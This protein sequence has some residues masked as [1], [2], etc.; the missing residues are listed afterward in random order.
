MSTTTLL[1]LAGFG[2]LMAWRIWS[3]RP[4]PERVAAARAALQQGARLVDVRTPGEF[5][6]GHL[7]GAINMPLSGLSNS[8]S[9]LGP[10]DHEIVLRC[11]SGARSRCAA[12]MLRRA[13]YEKVIDVGSLRNL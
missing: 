13:G 11:A 9:K 1:I 4:N 10:K 12:S 8:L 6:G 3:M 5:A 7:P 2:A